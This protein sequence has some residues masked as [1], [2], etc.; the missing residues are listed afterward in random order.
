MTY[1]Q[2]L[3]EMKNF[4][5]TSKQGQPRNKTQAKFDSILVELQQYGILGFKID[6]F[7]TLIEKPI[8]LAIRQR[9]AR[10]LR[11]SQ[12]VISQ[13]ITTRK[14]LMCDGTTTENPITITE[15]PSNTGNERKFYTS[16]NIVRKTIYYY[17]NN[18]Y[19]EFKLPQKEQKETEH[20]ER[21]LKE[22]KN[23]LSEKIKALMD[24]KET[25]IKEKADRNITEFFEKWF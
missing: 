10:Y 17:K 16:Y 14:Y 6:F 19:H 5:S 13:E 15:N 21:I 3:E 7:Y 20:I 22:T 4:I 18:N 11:N 24:F 1:E 23:A 9:L 12:V 8:P 2:T 25:K